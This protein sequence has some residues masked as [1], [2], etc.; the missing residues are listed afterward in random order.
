MTRNYQ[1]HNWAIRETKKEKR[2]VVVVVAGGGEMGML[3]NPSSSEVGVGV[4]HLHQAGNLGGVDCIHVPKPKL[5]LTFWG[6]LVFG[7]FIASSLPS[8]SHHFL[9]YKQSHL[10]NFPIF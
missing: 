6:R 2:R 8:L 9:L 1:G 3:G 10:T 5:K 4:S 7:K